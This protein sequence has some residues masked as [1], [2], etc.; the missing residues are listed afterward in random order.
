MLRSQGSVEVER[1]P[2]PGSPSDARGSQS[3]VAPWGRVESPLD[4]TS[5]IRTKIETLVS[6]ADSTDSS[7]GS[8]ELLLL[9]PLGSFA[10]AAELEEFVSSDPELAERLVVHK[11]AIA[12]VGSERFA[13]HQAD[14]AELTV[15]RIS[16]AR[17]FSARLVTVA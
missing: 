2:S 8:D 3:I 4:A 7:I 1:A 15:Q 17:C 5:A 6:I 9:L 13:R 10:S 11:G 16:L 14:R 12:F